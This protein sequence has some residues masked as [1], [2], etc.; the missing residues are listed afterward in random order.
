[1][2]KHWE[3]MTKKEL[4]GL[5][6]REWNRIGIYDFVLFVNT[7]KKHDSGYNLFAV[8]G[9]IGDD[10]EIA[11]YM[12]DFRMMPANYTYTHPG[13]APIKGFAFDCSMHGVF[14]LHSWHYQ[15]GVGTNTS[16]TD[17]FFVPREQK[18]EQQ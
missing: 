17:L 10:M 3:K 6:E 16:T 15:I 4:L 5:P 9:V 2:I 7:K 8:I 14:R 18:K 11:G 12:D 1:M 13:V